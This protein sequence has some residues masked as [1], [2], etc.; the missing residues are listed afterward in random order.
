MHQ[1]ISNEWPQAQT[2][3]DGLKNCAVFNAD[4]VRIVKVEHIEIE[5]KC[6]KYVLV[7]RKEVKE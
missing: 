7:S 4:R 5:E 6:G 1:A 2:K 3:P